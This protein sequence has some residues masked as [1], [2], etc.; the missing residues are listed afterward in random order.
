[1][2][3][4]CTKSVTCAVM[5]SRCVP[6]GNFRAVSVANWRAVEQ[7]VP[8]VG[9]DMERHGVYQNGTAPGSHDGVQ[10]VQGLRSM[11]PRAR[12]RCAH[13]AGHSLTRACERLLRTAHGMRLRRQCGALPSA[14]QQKRTRRTAAAR[15]SARVR[16]GCAAEPG[17]GE[18]VSQ[19]RTHGGE[20]DERRG[21][22]SA[23]GGWLPVVTASVRYVPGA[24][25]MTRWRIGDICL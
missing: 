15:G 24:R 4:R 23:H 17:S 5:G 16:R 18:R 6:G 2:L 13:F 21:G 9:I 14:A 10:H 19:A 22:R 25:K 11:S 1:M 3:A 20:R 12:P 7:S 8:V